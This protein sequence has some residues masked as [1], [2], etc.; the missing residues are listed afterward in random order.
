M[1]IHS[2]HLFRE[3]FAVFSILIFLTLRKSSQLECGR[4]S[5]ECFKKMSSCPFSSSVISQLSG[6]SSEPQILKLEKPLSFAEQQARFGLIQKGSK[7]VPSLCVRRTAMASGLYPFYFS[8][9]AWNVLVSSK[10][11]FKRWINLLHKFYCFAISLSFLVSLI[12]P[13]TERRLEYYQNITRNIFPV[14]ILKF[15]T[16]NYNCIT[17]TRHLKSKRF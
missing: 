5:L 11:N 3:H 17:W 4:D 15:I 16:L 14:V 6:G 1:E 10:L 13:V 8:F 7:R 2:D 12:S 9:S